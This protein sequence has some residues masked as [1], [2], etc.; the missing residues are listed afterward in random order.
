M[1]NT[2]IFGGGGKLSVNSCITQFFIRLNLFL[3]PAIVR[4][5]LPILFV[6][7]KGRVWILKRSKE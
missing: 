6:F 7:T 1:E 3:L 4:K 2:L 5:I